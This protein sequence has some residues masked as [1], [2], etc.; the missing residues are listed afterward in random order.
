MLFGVAAVSGI[1]LGLNLSLGTPAP[2]AVVGLILGG[3]AVWAGTLL[4]Q[5]GPLPQSRA[6]KV[7][8]F[9]LAGINVLAIV[10]GIPLFI[11]LAAFSGSYLALAAYLALAEIFIIVTCLLAALAFHADQARPAEGVL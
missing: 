1:N 6:L 3:V 9:V 7:V 11:L 2:M 8:F 5:P 4:A 10:G